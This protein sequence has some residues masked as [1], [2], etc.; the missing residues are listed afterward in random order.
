MGG[1]VS[2]VAHGPR[3]K[4]IV[5]NGLRDK[6]KTASGHTKSDLMK[7]KAGKIVTKKA[8]ANGRRAFKRVSKWND[9]V[10]QARREQKVKGFTA[11]KKSSKLYKRARQ[12]YDAQKK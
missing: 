8:H 5:F 11:I 6:D 10:T 2:T 12:I 9:A 4:Y 7:N 3:A 1:R